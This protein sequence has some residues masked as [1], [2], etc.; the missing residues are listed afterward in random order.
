[1]GIEFDMP[2]LDRIESTYCAMVKFEHE[3]AMRSVLTSANATAQCTGEI[4]PPQQDPR[5][6][7]ENMS[8]SKIRCFA[9]MNAP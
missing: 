9:L 6:F 5:H 1:V 7:F 8:R 2:A 3:T 4:R